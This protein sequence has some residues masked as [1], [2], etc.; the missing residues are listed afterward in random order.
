M[1]QLV[2]H[3]NEPSL[4]KTARHVTSNSDSGLIGLT[5]KHRQQENET[6]KQIKTKQTQNQ[7]KGTDSE[8]ACM[9]PEENTS[10]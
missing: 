4:L 1:S 5:N 2:W 8:L 9:N 6:N 7:N 3:V 10:G